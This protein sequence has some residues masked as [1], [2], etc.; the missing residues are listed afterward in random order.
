MSMSIHFR[1]I[2]SD[3]SRMFTIGQISERARKIVRV[4]EECVELGS[5]KQNHGTT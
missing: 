4:T 5:W 1:W 2:F 3:A